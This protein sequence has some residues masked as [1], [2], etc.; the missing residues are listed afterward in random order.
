M[1]WKRMCLS[2]NRLR[3]YIYTHIYKLVENIKVNTDN[4]SNLCI[5]NFTHIIGCDFQY[6]A[7]VTSHQLIK[8]N[9]TLYHELIPTPIG[10]DLTQTKELLQHQNLIQIL[11]EIKNNGQK[12]LI[13]VHHDVDKIT[14]VL[15]R[16]KKDGK[17]SWWETLFGWSP[18][19]MG[20]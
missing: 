7:P 9:Y 8:A 20:I 18:T 4:Y 1:C 13:I 17:H 3:I 19:A 11:H 12:T 5:C 10:M 15:Q 6:L 2:Q 14:G 16:V